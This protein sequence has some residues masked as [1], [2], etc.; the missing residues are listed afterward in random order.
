MQAQTTSGQ[1]QF[2][3]HAVE[4]GRL[5]GCEAMLPE[6]ADLQEDRE[7]RR[8]EFRASLLRAR[9]SQARME[10]REIGKHALRQLSAGFMER[11]PARMMADL[12]GAQ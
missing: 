6:A 9:A 12:A 2:A 8:I 11:R 10:S 1:T 4:S 5:A 7:R 3:G